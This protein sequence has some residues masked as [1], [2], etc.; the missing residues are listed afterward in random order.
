MEDITTYIVLA[1]LVIAGLGFTVTAI[2][3]TRQWH[4]YRQA[5][6]DLEGGRKIT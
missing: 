2:G 6:D 4:R 5:L 3:N 1:F